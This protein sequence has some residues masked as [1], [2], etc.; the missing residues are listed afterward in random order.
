MA[1]QNR[2]VVVPWDFSNLAEFALQHAVI[3]AKKQELGITLVHIVKKQSEIEPAKEKMEK[4]AVQCEKSYGIKPELVIREGSIFTEITGII[5]ESNA[6][7]AVMGTHGIKG[8]QKFTGS[9]ALKVIVGSAAPFIVVQK[10]PEKEQ[11]YKNIVYPIDFKTSAKENLIWA[12]YMSKKYGSKFHLCYVEATDNV[13]K[14]KILANISLAKN[15]LA[16]Q[17]V[18]YEIVKLEGKNVSDEALNY[19][20]ESHAD[21]IIIATT[22]NISFQDYVLGAH[23]QKI[24]ANKEQIPVMCVNPREGL[25]KYG[26]FN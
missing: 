6:T 21:M 20:R 4:V 16:E 10:K 15:Y 23:E 1:E 12:A 7:F 3:L 19:A 25:T 9:W 11:N 14:R 24:I 5:Q 2:P 13:F 17:E 18:D 22:K 26:S 8:M